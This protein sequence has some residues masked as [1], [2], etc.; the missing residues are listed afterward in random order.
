[1]VD[2]SDDVRLTESNTELKLLLEEQKLSTIPVLIFANKQDLETSLSA[3]EVN[4]TIMDNQI[5]MISSN[6]NIY[7]KF[8]C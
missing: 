2:S 3:Q 1:M 6:K 7:D 5:N 8:F 4:I